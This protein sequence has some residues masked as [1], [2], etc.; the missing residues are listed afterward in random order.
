MKIRLYREND[1]IPMLSLFRQTVK[2]VNSADYAVDQIKVWSGRKIDIQT[3]DENLLVNIVLV[4]FDDHDTIINFAN[5]NN[6]CYLECLFVSY[7]YQHHG[8]VMLLVQEL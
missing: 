6:S 4:A 7:R 8:C 2:V 5:M 1:A 3:L